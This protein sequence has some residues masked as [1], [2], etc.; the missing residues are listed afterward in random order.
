[1]N[2]ILIVLVVLMVIG[3]F[4]LIWK[5]AATWRWYHMVAASLLFLL[6]LVLLPV[7]AAVLTSRA[8]WLQ[9]QVS[10]EDRI[11]KGTRDQQLLKYGDPANPA[12]EVGLLPMQIELQKLMTES[13]RVWRRL[14]TERAA[15]DGI[16]LRRAS[17]QDDL[18]PE[19][20]LEP[21]E[22]PADAAAPIDVPL[23]PEGIVVYGFAERPQPQRAAEEGELEQ[24]TP[25]LLP[26]VYLGEFR[27]TASTPDSVTITPTLALEPTHAEMVFGG[28]VR[29]WSLYELLPTDGHEPF[30]AE[31]SRP[32]DDA[33]FGR[34]DEELVRRLLENRV[35]EATLENYLRDGQRAL[36][37]DPPLARW[38]K[39]VFTED[40]EETVDSAEQRGALDGGFF[41]AL[42][43]A[44]DSRLQRGDDGTVQFRQGD[45][46]I[47]KQEAA[48]DL[49][50]RG[51]A[52]LVDNYFVRPLNDYRFALRRIGRRMGELANRTEELEHQ[53][54]VIDAA[55]QLTI[56][57]LASEQDR[58]LKLEKDNEQIGKERA[59]VSAY[60]DRLDEQAKETR[61]QLATLYRENLIAVRELAAIQEQLR[62]AIEQREATA[63]SR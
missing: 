3:F 34:I 31:G 51:V 33:I 56:Q 2:I 25:Q 28:N 44:V 60:R 46:L 35:S 48:N 36:P 55:L 37:E 45:E 41:D 42:G 4:L 61:Q 17:P 63:V 53:H 26:T 10:L 29:S 57:M 11:D 54:E 30:I 13:G 6:V 9:L 24:Q 23:V 52:S 38:V 18:L 39:I 49:I 12:V 58:Q 32:D 16:V 19:E 5:S 8:A 1:M 7:T 40:Y 50:N 20:A 22:D 27:V 21:A 15:E 14:R 62:Q 43:Q 47:V 59:A